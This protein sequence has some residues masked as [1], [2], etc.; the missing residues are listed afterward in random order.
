LQYRTQSVVTV[1]RDT[2]SVRASQP[3]R[4]G[5]RPVAQ[6]GAGEELRLQLILRRYAIERL[7]HRLSISPHRDRFALKG[8]MLFT[9]WLEDPFRPT[10]DLDLLGYGDPAIPSIEAIFRAICQVA[11]DDDGLMF[12]AAGL[13]VE[14]IHEDQ[15]YGGA[16]VKTV[17]FL[18]KTRAC[19][20]SGAAEGL[21]ASTTATLPGS[22]CHIILSGS[23]TNRMSIEAK[24][25][26][27]CTPSPRPA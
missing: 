11:T 4:F 13:R 10:Q 7:L 5:A 3:P 16:R 15:Q 1:A 22:H 9:A 21:F 20:R 18:G 17:A 23:A 6:C 2:D 12:D 19:S 25:R 24:G 27:R 8:A 14:P 26:D